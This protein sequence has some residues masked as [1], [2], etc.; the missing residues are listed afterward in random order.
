[1]EE[2]FYNRDVNITGFS[3]VQ[4]LALPNKGYSVNYKNENS[5]VYFDNNLFKINNYTI[6]NLKISVN[7]SWKE[8]EDVTA[9]YI[10]YM[11]DKNSD[12][13]SYFRIDPNIYKDIIPGYCDGYSLD[14]INKDNYNLSAKF[15]DL[16]YCPDLNW[17][18]SEFLQN[19]F[20]DWENS[21]WYGIYDI[22]YTGV[23]D[24]KLNNFYYCTG[25][26][27]SSPDNSPTGEN[28]K[29][30]QDFF[31]AP[32]AG[33]NNN[34][35]FPVSKI[36]TK[37]QQ[38]SKTKYNN[39]FLDLDYTFSNLS[40][41]EAKSM[42]HFLEKKAGFRRFYHQIPSLYDRPKVYICTEWTHSLQYNEAHNIS[43]K[44]KEDPM[45]VLPE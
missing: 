42:L 13:L 30:T 10:K 18:G 43:V 34:V 37:Y 35:E 24:I 28:S 11:E 7:L 12:E 5:I 9:G 39:S 26:H 36:G 41:K 17:S 44:F 31:W 3:S 6:N 16:N 19:D 33:I 38:R 21:K 23:N 2:L 25:S 45:G 8:S 29:W 14:H 1:M 4:S 32:D 22:V 20:S 40:N 15:S 27:T